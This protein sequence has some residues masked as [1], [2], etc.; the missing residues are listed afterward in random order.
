M[1]R[2]PKNPITKIRTCVGDG[3]KSFF[4]GEMIWKNNPVIEFLGELDEACSSIG[5]IYI[6]NIDWHCKGANIISKLNENIE[7][8]KK[9]IFNVGGLCYTNSETFDSNIHLLSDYVKTISEYMEEFIEKV[10]LPELTGFIIPSKENGDVML[11]RAILRRCERSC[12]TADCLWAIPTLNCMSDFLFLV[13]W[14][15]DGSK[16]WV[17]I[18]K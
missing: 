3:G 12:V 17:G 4:K 18:G 13:A 11:A 16:Q 5:K 6:E 9:T 2:K 15:Q 14:L 7:Y 8:S 10:E 1:K